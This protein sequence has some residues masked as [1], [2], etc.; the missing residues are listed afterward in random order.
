MKEEAVRTETCCVYCNIPYG[1]TIRQALGVPIMAHCNSLVLDSEPTDTNVHTT[2][3]SVT[4]K[5]QH[6]VTAGRQDG[7]T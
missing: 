5:C 6:G 4:V 3:H 1:V 2:G 7:R